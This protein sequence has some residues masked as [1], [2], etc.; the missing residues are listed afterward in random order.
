MIYEHKKIENCFAD[1]QTFEYR[2][3]ITAE[4]FLALLQDGWT[5]PCNYK[6]RRPVFL[7]EQDGLRIK[8]MLAGNLIRVSFPNNSWKQRKKYFEDWMDQQ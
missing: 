2:L 1:S 8:G 7:A 5:T 4:T 3:P 6:L